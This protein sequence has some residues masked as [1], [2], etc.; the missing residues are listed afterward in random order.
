[1]LRRRGVGAPEEGRVVRTPLGIRTNLPSIFGNPASPRS[2]PLILEK[3][4]AAATKVTT[5]CCSPQNAV[6]MPDG[7]ESARVFLNIF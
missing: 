4:Q 1:M 3:M 2:K 6:N 7:F 5:A